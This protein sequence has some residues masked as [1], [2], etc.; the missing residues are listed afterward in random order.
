MGQRAYIAKKADENFER[1]DGGF[2][3]IVYSKEKV[4]Q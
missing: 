2:G 4:N 3:N 1:I